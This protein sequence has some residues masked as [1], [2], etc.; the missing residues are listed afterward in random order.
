MILLDNNQILIASMF[1]SFKQNQEMNEDYIRHLVL[2][3]YRMYR[4]KFS[5]TYGEL[6]ICN[7]SPYCWRKDFFPPYK[8]NRNKS[9][10][11][12][13]HDWNEIHNAMDNIREEIKTVFP[14]KN[15]RVDKTEAD[16]IIAVIC[17]HYNTTEK[18][19][20]ISSDKDF[21]QLQRMPN[22]KQYS[23]LKKTFIECENPKNFLLEHIIRG[24]SSDGIPNILSD[25]DVFVNDDKR[26]KRITKKVIEGLHEELQNGVIHERANWERN[27]T[28]I[29]LSYIPVEYEDEILEQYNTEE[30][31]G[32]EN[33]LNYFIEKKLK[34]LMEYMGDF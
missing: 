1:Q 26:Q 6:V 23:P 16:D 25:D 32:R 20:I 21:Q 7:D 22:V 18:I 11:E 4:T 31:K 17:K 33:L 30:T 9:K 19:I 15:I 28:L 3:T 13:P 8:Q 2:N 27:K 12:S 29:D 10:K 5:K 14:Y 24:D 34:N